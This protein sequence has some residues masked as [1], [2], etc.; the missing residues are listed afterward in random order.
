MRMIDLQN[1]VAIAEAG[2]LVAAGEKLGISQP[3]LS[4]SVARL[5]RSLGMK[6]VERSGRG[7]AL[8]ESGSVFLGHAR[9]VCLGL[10]D[11]TSAIR[12]LRYG[13]AGTVRFGIGYGVPQ[14][15]IGHACKSLLGH[16]DVNLEIVG[17]LTDSL[18]R[19]VSA[20]ELDF[21]VT[22][23]EPLGNPSLSW[24]PL[25]P[26]PIVPVAPTFHEIFKVKKITWNCLA[27]QSWLAFNIGTHARSWFDDQ[28]L[29][30]GLPAPRVISLQ[31]YP[32]AL[33]LGSAIN[34]ISLVPASMLRV[35]SR[36]AKIREVS[37]P[38][39][40]VSTRMVG[41]IFRRH[42]YMIPASYKLM[43]N[44]KQSADKIV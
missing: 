20:G 10:R 24:T 43:E 19:S 5:E 39:D 35:P 1:F 40:W 27:E 4:K 17:G 22:S 34:A 13:Q 38:D 8:T 16:L 15:L 9:G 18:T 21:A 44:I 3:T 31:N 30:R 11:A 37:T 25:F 12:Q 23:A 32:V 29:H 26:D 6:L 41:I 7:I 33:S 36:P 28:F 2:T 14:E 42:G